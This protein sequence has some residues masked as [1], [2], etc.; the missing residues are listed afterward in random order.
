MY[1]CIH[2]ERQRVHEKGQSLMLRSNANTH[3]IGHFMHI[4]GLLDSTG[5][6]RNLRTYTHT[7]KHTHTHTYARAHTYTHT[8]THT[9]THAHTH[10]HRVSTE[11][12][13]RWCRK[14]SSCTLAANFWEYSLQVRRSKRQCKSLGIPSIMALR[15]SFDADICLLRKR[16]IKSWHV[17]TFR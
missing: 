12:T 4:H 11:S 9:H 14:K 13:C 3:K 10:T 2:C 8:H 6:Q 7:H 5:R 15:I 1:V 16:R 17:R